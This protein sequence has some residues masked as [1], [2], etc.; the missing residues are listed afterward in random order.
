MEKCTYCAQ[1]IQ[2]SKIQV[3]KFKPSDLLNYSILA[4]TEQIY[5]LDNVVSIKV[6]D[7]A[8]QTAC[9]QVCPSDRMPSFS[10]IF[11]IPESEVSK[12]KNQPSRLLCI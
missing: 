5:V 4:K 10:A 6:P 9:Q 3:Q 2:E 7:G 8:I 1:R 11:L 12:L